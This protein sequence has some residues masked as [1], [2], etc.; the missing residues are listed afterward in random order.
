MATNASAVLARIRAAFGARGQTMRKWSVERARLLGYHEEGHYSMVVMTIKR[1]AY[2][3]DAPKGAISAGIMADLRA[4]LGPE[5]IPPLKAAS[6]G[7]T[8]PAG[9][10]RLARTAQ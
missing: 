3:T 7:A 2:R 6:E 8:Q 4:E 5:V 1:W 9:R 10:R